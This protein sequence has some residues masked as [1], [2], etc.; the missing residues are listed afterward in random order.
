MSLFY[1]ATE[2]EYIHKCHIKQNSM[3]A[4]HIV[5]LYAK[6]SLPTMDTNVTDLAAAALDIE[7]CQIF[8]VI[9]H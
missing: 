2:V 7:R 8:Q 1:K 9:W 5:Q 4:L 3:L 6:Q